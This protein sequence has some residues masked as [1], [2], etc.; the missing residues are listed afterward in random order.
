MILASVLTFVII[1]L[2]SIDMEP[3]ASTHWRFAY[4]LLWTLLSLT[5][6]LPGYAIAFCMTKCTKW[7]VSVAA[8][9]MAI[10][11]IQFTIN[12][13]YIEYIYPLALGVVFGG[14]SGC[15][16]NSGLRKT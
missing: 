8:V 10:L 5:L 6:Y 12:G 11:I 14:I 13:F 1:W 2:L 9:I 16:Y 15:I 4:S 3:V 7:R